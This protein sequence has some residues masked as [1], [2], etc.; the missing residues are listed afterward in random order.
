MKI[1]VPDSWKDISISQYQKFIALGDIDNTAKT[2][3]A[4][5]ILCN[6]TK[7]QV[8]KIPLKDIDRMYKIVSKLTDEETDNFDLQQFI[9]IDGEKYG[10]HPNLSNIQT[11]EYADIEEYMKLDVIENLHNIMSVLYRPVV[12]ETMSK[13]QIDDYNGDDDIKEKFKEVKMDVALGML[14]FFYNLGS[15]LQKSSSSY[16]KELKMR[17]EILTNINPN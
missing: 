17:E 5:S 14:V 4:I 6:L 3:E 16:L 8:K 10:F 13:Y 7:S 2:I 12:S 9:E 11:G 1:I 15:E